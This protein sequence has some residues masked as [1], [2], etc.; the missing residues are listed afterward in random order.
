VTPRGSLVALALVALALGCSGR[1]VGTAAAIPLPAPEPAHARAMIRT[2]SVVVEVADPAIALT[3][4]AELARELGGF[5]QESRREGASAA[6]AVL[7]VP[8]SRLDEA[9]DRLAALGRERERSSTTAD[10]TEQVA[11]LEASLTNDRALRDRLRAL[12]AR[13][14]TVEEVLRV[15]GELTRLQTQIDR[16]E[17]RLKRLRSEVEL[18]TLSARF[19]RR[20]ILGPLG[21]ALKGVAWVVEKLFVIRE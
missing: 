8:S 15:E 1:R 17:G 16:T 10:V 6:T 13:A 19:E 21:Y 14:K 4:S 18:S 12:L 7:R 5:V 3:R 2:A 9:L 20:R 11:D